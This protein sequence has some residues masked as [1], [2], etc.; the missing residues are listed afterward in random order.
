MNFGLLML[1][2]NLLLLH[3]R[4]LTLNGLLL[5]DTLSLNWNRLAL[6]RHRLALNWHRLTCLTL[7]LL[8]L[9]SLE[10]SCRMGLR[11]CVGRVGLLGC[12]LR[13]SEGLLLLLSLLI[14][15]LLLLANLSSLSR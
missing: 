14:E 4:R 10:L 8:L 9:L 2:V 5:G 13:R 7:E 15:M 6:N 3:L 12:L 1:L 11:L